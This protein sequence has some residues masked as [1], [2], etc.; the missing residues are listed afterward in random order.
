MAIPPSTH[1]REVR[2]TIP[3]QQSMAA[4]NPEARAARPST[5][6]PRLAEPMTVGLR[7]GGGGE[8]EPSKAGHIANLILRRLSAAV[9]ALAS[10]ALS[11]ASAAA[12]R[13]PPASTCLYPSA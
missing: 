7:G 9:F 6:Q 11:A 10:A 12:R 4:T 3:Q 8:G 2:I 13:T 5:E 1:T